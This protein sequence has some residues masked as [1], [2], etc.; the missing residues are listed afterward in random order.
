[1]SKRNKETNFLN[2]TDP[3]A[4]IKQYLLLMLCKTK[5]YTDL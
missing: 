5:S 1:M 3:K 2:L 4:W